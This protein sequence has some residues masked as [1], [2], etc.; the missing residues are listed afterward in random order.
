MKGRVN[1]FMAKTFY[2]IWK[3]RADDTDGALLLEGEGI[4]HTRHRAFKRAKKLAKNLNKEWDFSILVRKIHE[5]S[6]ICEE[7]VFEAE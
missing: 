4:F 5:D 2:T 1:N 3:S 7:W 6:D